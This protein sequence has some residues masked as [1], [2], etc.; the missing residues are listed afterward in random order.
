MQLGVTL[1]VTER[2]LMGSED[3]AVK[4]RRN[5]YTGKRAQRLTWVW[6]YLRRGLEEKE[7]RG[8][9]LGR[10]SLAACKMM[11]QIDGVVEGRSQARMERKPKKPENPVIK[12]PQLL[13]RAV[14]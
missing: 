9:I 7:K 1:G 4:K 12:I 6:D 13:K 11:L 5:R 3:T 2:P 10:E 14:E 8:H